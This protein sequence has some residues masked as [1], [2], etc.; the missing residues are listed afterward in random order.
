MPAQVKGLD[1][2]DH[3]SVYE[4][5]FELDKVLPVK[6]VERLQQELD[7]HFHCKSTEPVVSTPQVATESNDDDD[8]IPFDNSTPTTNASQASSSSEDLDDDPLDDDT[9]KSLL[10][11]LDSE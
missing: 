1:D 6:S 5:C 8:D 11:G 7:E 9:V 2:T 4:K 3:E 10:A